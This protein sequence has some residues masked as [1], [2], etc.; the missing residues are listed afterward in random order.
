M[1]NP[2]QTPSPEDAPSRKGWLPDYLG[3]RRGRLL[4]F[5]LLYVT[6]GIPLGFTAV[7]V[8]TKMRRQGLGPAEIGSFIAMLYMPWAWKWL[9]APVV[10][11][12]YS[13]RWGRRR[14]WIVTMQTLMAFTLLFS[15]GIDYTADLAFY[16]LVILFVNIF[17]ATQDVAIDGL[18]CTTL[19]E[20]ERGVAN[21]L[22]F[23][24]AQI[25]NA[26]GGAGVLFLSD[27]LSGFDFGTDAD[28]GFSIAS[29]LTVVL[30]LAITLFVAL[31]LRERSLKKP[32]DEQASTSDAKVRTSRLQMI[33]GSIRTYARDAIGAF[34]GSRSSM[35]AVLVALL[36]CGSLALSLGLA[37]NLQVELGMTNSQI[38][39][40]TLVSTL[41]W[42]PCC[43]FGGWL[44]DRVGRRVV[45]SVCAVVLSV[46]PLIMASYMQSEGYIMPVKT[47]VGEVAVFSAPAI[48]VTVFWC[49]SI[50]F[51]VFQG[52]LFGTRT[53]F[54]MDVCDPKVAATQFTAY[55]SILNLTIMYSAWWQGWA[56]EKYGYPTTL[57]VDALL[58]VLC[59]VLIPFVTPRPSVEIELDS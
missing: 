34:L 58:G 38:A 22:M 10:D 41:V 33:G 35:L 30:I 9:V 57:T 15:M 44:S 31:P 50:G 45:L 7:A 24:G 52:M 18:A 37:A 32:T 8:A 6:E 39:L 19:H 5:F 3:T 12:V 48:L 42:A 47:P 26:L 53:A 59:V 13:E 51:S 27:W 55:M 14:V 49:V 20:D 21:G 25:G 2:Y 1:N 4:A 17:G 36:P 29:L 40:L 54:F 46:P 16:T 23:A 43:V 11:V 28:V 56:I